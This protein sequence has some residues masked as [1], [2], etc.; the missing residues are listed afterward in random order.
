MPSKLIGFI[1]IE[2]YNISEEVSYL[3]AIPKQ[4]EE[5]DEFGQ[6][7]WKN[8]SLYNSSGRK[9]DTQYKNA[10]QCIATEYMDRCP[11]VKRFIEDNFSMVSLRMVRARNLIDGMVIQHRDF[12]ELDSNVSYF[13]VFIPLE[14]NEDA[15]HSDS[16]GVFQMKP[17]EV[18]YLDAGIDHAAINFSSQSRMFLCLDFVFNDEFNDVDIFKNASSV[19][20]NVKPTYKQRQ[21]LPES[22]RET[23]V[24]SMSLI[25]SKETFKDIL[26]AI[27]K[28]HFIYDIE[29]AECYEWFIDACVK[30]GHQDLELKARDLQRYLIEKREL[31]ERFSI[32]DWTSKQVA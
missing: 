18:W 11:E 20:F 7:Y 28:Y 9:N 26:F 31:N 5:Y 14:K 32:N 15:Y 17:G 13:R 3:N 19:V 10:N 30:G 25:L 1:D 6:G 2:K 12:V 24:E 29:V 4:R 22:V 23:I 21:A 16:T 8:L 27:S